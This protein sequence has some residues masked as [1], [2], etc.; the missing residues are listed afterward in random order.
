MSFSVI[1]PHKNMSYESHESHESH[2]DHLLNYSKQFVNGKNELTTTLT[3]LMNYDVDT[4]Q[5]VQWISKEL[6]RIQVIMNL[7]SSHSSYEP[8]APYVSRLAKL[9]DHLA[10]HENFP[11]PYIRFKN[12]SSFGAM[13][14]EL[15]NEME[16]IVVSHFKNECPYLK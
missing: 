16:E 7:E 12:W 15:C 2:E 8:F 6:D 9:F 3:N 11:K 1:S 13:E 4:K 14:W 5:T 10:R